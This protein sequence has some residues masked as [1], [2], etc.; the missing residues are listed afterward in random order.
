MAGGGVIIT[1]LGPIF[2]FT[3]WH[4]VSFQGQSCLFCGKQ[5]QPFGGGFPAP[6]PAH[7]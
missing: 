1:A 5:F 6:V 7:G 4:P 3:R 2:D